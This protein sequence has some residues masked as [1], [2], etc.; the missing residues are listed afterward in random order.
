MFPP[1]N[2]YGKDLIFIFLQRPTE[3][4]LSILNFGN[5]LDFCEH[6]DSISHANGCDGRLHAALEP[7]LC[8]VTRSFTE[9]IF[10]LKLLHQKD[11][12]VI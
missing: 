4:N 7:L 8:N 12:S 2:D 11:C 3:R 1:D 6:Q 5:P 10:A 9:R